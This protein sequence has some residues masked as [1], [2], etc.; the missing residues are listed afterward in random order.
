MMY[1][2]I[3]ISA[4]RV[5]SFMSYCSAL[6][7]YSHYVIVVH[8]SHSICF[9]VA[10]QSVHLHLLGSFQHVSTVIKWLKQ[11]CSDG[12]VFVLPLQKSERAILLYNLPSFRRLT[13]SYGPRCN[14]QEV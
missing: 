4:G 9:R 5:P 12:F 6:Y 11:F 10:V 7:T 1:H 14:S 3:L 13:S 2:M 8:L